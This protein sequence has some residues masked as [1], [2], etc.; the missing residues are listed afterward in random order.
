[1]GTKFL[2]IAF[3]V[4]LSPAALKATMTPRLSLEN[5][6]ER[7][8][9]IVHGRC[10]RTWSAWDAD[11]QS[12]WT[13]GEIEIQSSLKGGG[14]TTVVVSEP[15]GRAGGLEMAIEGVPQY[16][17][18]EEVV[19]FLYRTPIGYLRARGLG[20]GKYRVTSDPGGTQRRVRLILD[21]VSLVNSPA[22]S[23]LPSTQLRPLDGAPLGEFLSRVR[24]LVAGQSK[25]VR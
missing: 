19:V 1:M 21:G 18:G 8:E 16:Q 22:A 7:S 2:L 23:P 5:L 25:G 3:V 24:G 20:Q 15:G 11:R 9:L 10:L 6:V 17:P 12:I 4:W 13:H 14:T